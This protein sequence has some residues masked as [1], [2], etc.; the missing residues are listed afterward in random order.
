VSSRPRKGQ[1]ADGDPPRAKAHKREECQPLFRAA[2]FA[3]ASD[4]RSPGLDA[5]RRRA[6]GFR[7]VDFVVDHAKA[8]TTLNKGHVEQKA[9]KADL[10][11]AAI[12]AIRAAQNPPSP[13]STQSPSDV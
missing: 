9:L 13:L 10:W 12:D 5:R 8:P 1:A 4:P 11:R 2:Y 3:M 6:L 7:A